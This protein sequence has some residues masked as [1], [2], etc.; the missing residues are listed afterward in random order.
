MFI[1]LVFLLS[2]CPDPYYVEDYLIDKTT[3]ETVDNYYPGKYKITFVNPMF[4]LVA[5]SKDEDGNDKEEVLNK[6]KGIYSVEGNSLLL[7]PLNS[8]T[9][10]LTNEYEEAKISGDVLYMPVYVGAGLGFKNTYLFKLKN[11]SQQN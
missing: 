4:I 3:W 10:T 5:V 11:K 6:G 1:S 2:A 8:K 7:N 9:N